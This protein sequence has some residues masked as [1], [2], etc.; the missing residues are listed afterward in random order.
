MKGKQTE[1][2]FLNGKV[3]EIGRRHGIPT[4]AN[5]VITSLIK[6]LEVKR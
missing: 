5:E 3:V 4:P 2:D 6:F 1:I